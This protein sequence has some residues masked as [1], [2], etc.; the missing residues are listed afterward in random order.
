MTKFDPQLIE[1]AQKGDPAALGLLLD[2]CQVDIRN[3][4][5]AQC[6]AADIEDATQET[7][8]AVAK[9]IE[10]LKNIAAFSSWLFTIL[11]RQCQR[12]LRIAY[13]F[14][15]RETEAEP[16]STTS[17]T[18]LRLDIVAAL[19]SLPPHYLQIILLRDFEE[20]SIEEISE[21][22]NEPVAAV[23]SRLHRARK[24]IREYLLTTY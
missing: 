21:E 17:T 23:K 24:L 15:Q 20:R 22:L 10:K 12:A 18:D 1:K 9:D 11:K 2:I 7:L 19:E 14:F 5:K 8:M 16:L 6:K 3:Y 4:A 13:H